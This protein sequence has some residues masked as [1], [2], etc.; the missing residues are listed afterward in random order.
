LELGVARLR[1]DSAGILLDSSRFEF[2]E[3]SAELPIRWRCDC[4][5]GELPI[6][7]APIARWCYV[8]VLA[9]GRLRIQWMRRHSQARSVHAARP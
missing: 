9:R 3:H 7:S 1:T 6:R 5:V 8:R 2:V 4:L